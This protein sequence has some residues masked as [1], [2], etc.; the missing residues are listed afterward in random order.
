MAAR[1]AGSSEPQCHRHIRER[2]AG[3][4]WIIELG[5]GAVG[6]A[7]GKPFSPRPLCPSPPA[8]QPKSMLRLGAAALPMRNQWTCPATPS[9]VRDA[10]RYAQRKTV[11]QVWLCCWTWPQ[12]LRC[13]GFP[14]RSALALMAVAHDISRMPRPGSAS[15][16][17][18]RMMVSFQS[19]WGIGC[20]GQVSIS[21]GDQNC[22][23]FARGQIMAELNH[24]AFLV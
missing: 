20:P 4:S 17:R 24:G 6:C 1:C 5:G 7:D 9:S 22:A 23:A 14:D 2:W 10:H 12:L 21:C 11:V 18:R 15:A 8:H 3:A 13:N 16:W 19:P